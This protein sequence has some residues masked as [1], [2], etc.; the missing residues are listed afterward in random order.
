MI[1][2]QQDTLHA[3]LNAVTRASLKSSLMAAFS[4]VR[5]DANTNGVMH[6]S[7]FN[8]ETA[9]RAAVNVDCNEDLSVC[10][11]AMT[12]K[13]VVETLA[14]EI[15]LSVEQNSLILQGASTKT[16]LRIVDEPLPVIGEE[17]IQTIATLSGVTFRSLARVLPFASTDDARAVLQVLHLML[18]QESVIA[19]TADGYSAGT[20]RE[21]IEGPAE[22]TSVFLPLSFAR[23]LSTLVDDRDKIRLGTSGPN[24]YIFQITNAE[25]SKDLT[26]ATV[27]S[28]ENFPSAQI[29]TLT[30]EARQNTVTT[31]HIQQACLT[32]TIRMVHAM[33][34]QS[35]FIKAV[36]GIVK[37]A[38][39]E[40]DTGQARNILEGTAS[41]EDASIWVSAAYLKRAAEACKG[42]LAIRIS[43]GQKPILTEAGSFTAVIMPMM[44]EGNKDPFPEDEAIAISLPEMAMA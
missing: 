4:L 37:M 3:A 18:D 13:A 20:V 25:S 27:T 11:D 44:V 35:A 14:G 9:A 6:L 31:L 10:V 12:L 17:S 29:T 21:S 26:L 15:R 34:A 32:Q 33:N 38:S 36:N 42:E 39:A 1:T 16:T 5:L 40:T 43:G 2:I 28:A 30:Q 41:G 8:G 7:C 24:R 23:V 19:Q 22:P